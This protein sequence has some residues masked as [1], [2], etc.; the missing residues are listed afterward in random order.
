MKI[1]LAPLSPLQWP[2]NNPFWEHL[3][4]HKYTLHSVWLWMVVFRVEMI[5]NLHNTD[6]S[7]SKT[8][9]SLG[10][11]QATSRPGL[12]CQTYRY[13]VFPCLVKECVPIGMYI[14]MYSVLELTRNT[15]LFE[16]H[17]TYLILCMPD[18]INTHTHT[19]TSL[20]LWNAH[21]RTHH[22]KTTCFCNHTRTQTSFLKGSSQWMQMTHL[23]WGSET[24]RG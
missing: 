10:N 24:F 1:S 16:I 14:C 17:N 4:D 20:F 3:S 22:P 12:C 2:F 19:V 6:N 18:C 8:V 5:Y 7:S 11:Q 23:A 15:R 13:V 21:T 9:M